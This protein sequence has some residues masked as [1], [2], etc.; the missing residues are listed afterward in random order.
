MVLIIWLLVNVDYVL[1][2]VYSSELN[3]LYMSFYVGY[4]RM[5]KSL[6]RIFMKREIFI[7]KNVE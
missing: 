2:S 5:Y 1:C 7:D 6:L 3:V 4:E